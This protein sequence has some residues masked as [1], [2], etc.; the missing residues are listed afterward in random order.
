[1]VDKLDIDEATEVVGA[2]GKFG[3]A[4]TTFTGSVTGTVDDFTV[5]VRA[6]SPLDRDLVG[7]LNWMVSA[8]GSSVRTDDGRTG[9]ILRD[10]VTAVDALTGTDIFGG[11]TVTGAESV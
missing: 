5:P 10:T 7:K 3:V 11:T 9:M 8:F 2:A 4:A 6:S 1:M